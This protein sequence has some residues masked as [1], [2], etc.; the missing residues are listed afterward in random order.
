MDGILSEP[1]SVFMTP[2]RALE[3]SDLSPGGQPATNVG[4]SFQASRAVEVVLNSP[5][6]ESKT[7]DLSSSKRL[8]RFSSESDTKTN[9]ILSSS[10]HNFNN[11][12]QLG[13]AALSLKSLIAAEETSYYQHAEESI[14]RYSLSQLDINKRVTTNN[15]EVA[16]FDLSLTTKSGDE[17]EFSYS[18]EAGQAVTGSGENYSY[19]EVIVNFDLKGD[20]SADE[21]QALEDFSEKLSGFANDFFSGFKN[22]IDLSDLD[23]FGADVFADVSLTMKAG[24]TD[25]SLRLQDTET[26]RVLNVMWDS[27]LDIDRPRNE[28]QL[29]L[30]KAG[31][32]NS[33]TDKQAK[34]V[35]ML[36]DM[37]ENSIDEAHGSD[38]QT[39]LIGSALASLHSGISMSSPT[40]HLANMTTGLADY[41]LTFKGQIDR[42]MAEMKELDNEALRGLSEGVESLKMKQATFIYKGGATLQVVQEQ[43]M[44]MQANYF[45]PL[46]G[47]DA[48]DFSYQSFMYHEIDHKQSMVSDETVDATSILSASLMKKEEH[49][50]Q[51]SEYT[52]GVLTNLTDRNHSEYTVT[53]ATEILKNIEQ[54]DVLEQLDTMLDF[55]YAPH[56]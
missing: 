13:V 16:S 18:L 4:S 38:Q 45:A 2:S 31:T 17:I 43:S 29:L 22:G 21:K 26:S 23:L 34:S 32:I 49:E 55:E 7:Y 11:S 9:S 20:L 6:L 36:Q 50:H 28:L 33:A 1:A 56:A 3:P 44:S 10:L 51:V 46:P 8:T 27:G 42:P 19:Q 25:F 15:Y 24:N 48:P 12:D 39:S 14:S 5:A 37:V 35:Q 30:S 54:K 41:S 52:D 47:L 40:K 53:D